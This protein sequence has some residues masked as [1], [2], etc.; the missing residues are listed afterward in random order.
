METQS[1]A[2]RR[3]RAIPAQTE[4]SLSA[5]RDRA[6]KALKAAQARLRQLEGQ[7][8]DSGHPAQGRVVYLALQLFL[9][10]RIGFRAVSRVLTLLR[11]PLASRKRRA[12]KPSSIGSS[13]SHRPHRRGPYAS[14]ACP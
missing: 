9:V 13:G 11:G 4:R 14:G 1:Q 10:A 2:A 3:A 12:R 7:L 8:Q 6:T 5:E